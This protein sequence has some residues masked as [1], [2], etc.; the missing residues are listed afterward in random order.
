MPKVVTKALYFTRRLIKLRITQVK[1]LAL[2]PSF[3]H[4]LCSRGKRFGA[5]ISKNDCAI[6]ILL[7]KY[8]SVG[9][10]WIWINLSRELAMKALASM[11]RIY[12]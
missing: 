6:T 1:K 12:G 8:A 7:L 5:N 9:Y 11:I 3:I 2:K 10:F 4:R